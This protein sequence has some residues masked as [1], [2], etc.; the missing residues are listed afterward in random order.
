MTVS[1]YLTDSVTI[2][3]PTVDEWRNRTVSDVVE[4]ARVDYKQMMVTDY[5]GKLVLSPMQVMVGAD[6]VVDADCRIVYGDAEY[7][8]VSIEKHQDFT[9]RFLLLRLM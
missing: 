4:A 1:I 2:R 7:R 8:I 3:T 5:T 9:A 6:A